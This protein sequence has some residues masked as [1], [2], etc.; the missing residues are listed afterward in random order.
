M[1]AGSSQARERYVL[2]DGLRRLS[3]T[4]SGV[5]PERVVTAHV[6][7]PPSTYGLAET[8]LFYQQVLA[9]LRVVPG[10]AAS[11]VSSALPLTADRVL[12]VE[13]T[14]EGSTGPARQPARPLAYYVSPG[15]FAA[16]GI[17]AVNYGPGDPLLAHAQDEHVEIGKIRD[18]AATLHRWLAS[19]SF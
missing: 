3:Q 5:D 15:Y 2:L 11:A 8:R 12:G 18:G 4:T 13:V 17:P 6:T 16:M 9:R 14:A 1:G 7:L 10:V 19:P